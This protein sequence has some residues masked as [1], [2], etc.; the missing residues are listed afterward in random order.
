MLISEADQKSFINAAKK[1]FSSSHV[2]RAYL[3]QL[4][5]L[6][7]E[8]YKNHAG[9]IGVEVVIVRNDNDV[10][11][12]ASRRNSGERV[13]FLFKLD[14]YPGTYFT[15]CADKILLPKQ[16]QTNIF[17]RYLSEEEQA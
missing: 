15:S 7:L 9:E 10:G 16:T 8:F 5:E 2:A 14:F 11:F 4:P 12:A 1:A 6:V 17:R 13:L 3:E